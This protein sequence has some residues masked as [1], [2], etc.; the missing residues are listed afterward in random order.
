ME[1]STTL[2]ANETIAI[3]LGNFDGVHRG[4]QHLMHELQETAQALH[5]KPVLVTFSPHTLMVVRPDLDVSYLT[6]LEEKL[7]LTQRYGG[8]A[9]NI[10]INFTQA[11]ASMSATEFMDSLATHFTI[12]AM[13]VGADFSLGHNRMG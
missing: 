13:V 6:T 12:K 4:H 7:A 1:Y 5:C 3:T 11:V 8:I 9:D 10:V 2:V